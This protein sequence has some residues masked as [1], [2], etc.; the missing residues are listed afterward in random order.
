MYLSPGKVLENCFRKRVRTLPWAQW[1]RGHVS[2]FHR[3][4]HALLA[5]LSLS[6][7]RV[8]S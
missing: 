2:D 3:L 7:K 6:R 1:E 5:R 4:L 8:F